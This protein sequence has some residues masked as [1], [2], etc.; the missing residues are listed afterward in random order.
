V[1]RFLIVFAIAVAAVASAAAATTATVPA[2]L[3][4]SWSRKVTAADNKR[5]SKIHASAQTGVWQISIAK[6]GALKV[7][8]PGRVKAG[9]K[10]S[11]LKGTLSVTG[12][13]LSIKAGCPT[14]NSYGWKVSG[15]LLT[16]TYVSDKNCGDR[17]AVFSGVWKRKTG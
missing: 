7:F 6:S 17:A 16:I 14:K 4:G 1:A 13:R 3:V 11:T 8:D 2:K 12:G 10:T 9:A 5:F 15:R